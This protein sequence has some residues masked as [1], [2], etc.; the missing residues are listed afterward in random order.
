MMIILVTG[1]KRF[2][3]ENLINSYWIFV[4]YIPEGRNKT[5]L[6]NEPLPTIR[7]PD[8]FLFSGPQVYRISVTANIQPARSTSNHWCVDYTDLIL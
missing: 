3:L 6:I 4:Y 8:S 7:L 1:W 2:S 5:R